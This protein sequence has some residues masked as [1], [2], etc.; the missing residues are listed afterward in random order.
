MAS[1][2][3]Y[4]PLLVCR[5][6]S[7]L[8]TCISPFDSHSRPFGIGLWTSFPFCRWENWHT[9]GIGWTLPGDKSPR[10]FQN[11]VNGF[12]P[13]WVEWCRA[14]ME[15]WC[16]RRMEE[17]CFQNFGRGLRILRAGPSDTFLTLRGVGPSGK[18]SPGMLISS[19][20]FELFARYWVDLRYGRLSLILSCRK[21]PFQ[22]EEGKKQIISNAVCRVPWRMWRL[23]DTRGCLGKLGH[24]TVSWQ[25][26]WVFPFVDSFTLARL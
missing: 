24:L 20:R 23:W 8:F 12:Y 7:K 21:S 6:D 10:L 15:C 2:N 1:T 11:S 4:V 14:P 17:F 25:K 3:V 26:H 5:P 9:E 22:R 13:P 19:S 18:Q 16:W